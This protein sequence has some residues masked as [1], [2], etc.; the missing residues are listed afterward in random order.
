[1]SLLT[2]EQD[3]RSYGIPGS[4]R[5]L[6]PVQGSNTGC[7]AKPS[8][9]SVIVDWYHPSMLTDRDFHCITVVLFIKN[10]GDFNA[11]SGVGSNVTF[12]I[13]FDLSLEWT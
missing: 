5:I 4:D 8:L 6:G 12:N 2:S 1:M 11:L 9:K 3:R 7:E 13:D 10:H